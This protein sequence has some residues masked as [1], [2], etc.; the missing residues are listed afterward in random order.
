MQGHLKW[1]QM[2]SRYKLRD[3]HMQAQVF[4]RLMLNTDCAS[5]TGVTLTPYQHKIELITFHN[6]SL[7]LQAY[8]L[9]LSLQQMNPIC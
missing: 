8:E 5:V 3:R 9:A 7:Q 2:V 1:R 4:V 6:R